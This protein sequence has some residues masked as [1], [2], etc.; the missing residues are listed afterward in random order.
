MEPLKSSEYGSFPAHVHPAKHGAW[1]NVLHGMGI[2]VVALAGI[3]WWTSRLYTGAH[4]EII[5][6]SEFSWDQVRD[7]AFVARGV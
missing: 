6:Q 7:F 5:I 4:T 3:A 2:A 1:R